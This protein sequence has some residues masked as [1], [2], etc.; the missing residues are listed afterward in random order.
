MSGACGISRAPPKKKKHETTP[1]QPRPRPHRR[2]V[3]DTARHTRAA[4][5]F[6]GRAVS[7]AP[8]PAR[9]PRDP[10]IDCSRGLAMLLVVMGHNAAFVALAWSTVD[11]FY[12]F[13]VAALFFVSGALLRPERFSASRV[14][15][16]IL[17]PF[18]VVG[19]LLAILKTTMRD[20][21]LPNALLGLLWGTGPTVPSVQ[22]WFL[23]ALF[24]S[25]LLAVA[26]VRGGFS[27]Q[28]PVGAVL[29]LAV[30]LVLA[31]PALQVPAPAWA[32]SLR[33]GEPE[34]PL[35]WFWNIDLL[36]LAT[37]FV[38]A[39]HGAAKAGWLAR[40]RPAVALPATL[41]VVTVCFLLGARMDMNARL[42]EEF[43]LAI[44]AA[45]AGCLTVWACGRVIG[46]HGPALAVRALTLVGQHSMQILAFHVLVQNAAVS[47]VQRFLGDGDLALFAATVT[48]I[49][50]GVLLPL[51][52]SLTID[53]MQTRRTVARAL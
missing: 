25:L 20:E 35:G 27:I 51:L 16:R 42:I 26:I 45:L 12:F 10:G 17:L 15:R 50:A 7:A 49:G 3:P 31:W 2:P 11:W 30:L 47:V 23:P 13:R 18:A 32:E 21:S 28:R 44:I 24:V 22:L 43:P 8:S 38:L 33:Y 41:A 37:F 39:G 6:K 34:G 29:V 14:A 4:N 46:R 5:P 19:V 36:P 1:P 52:L 9:T 48:G 40:L 53:R